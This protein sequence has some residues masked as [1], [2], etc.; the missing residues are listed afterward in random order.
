MPVSLQTLHNRVRARG[1]FVRTD[2]TDW[3]HEDLLEHFH[4]I[5][6]HGETLYVQKEPRDSAQGAR[7]RTARRMRAV[8]AQNDVTGHVLQFDEALDCA[9]LGSI[10]T[11]QGTFSHDPTAEHARVLCMHFSAFRTIEAGVWGDV[12]D[13][14]LLGG[15]E[16]L[17][18]DATRL[19]RTLQDEFVVLDNALGNLTV[20][21]TVVLDYDLVQQLDL[22]LPRDGLPASEAWYHAIA[23]H[24][25]LKRNF[26]KFD[27]GFLSHIT[28]LANLWFDHDDPDVRAFVGDA[29]ERYEELVQRFV[30][31]VPLLD[32]SVANIMHRRV[33]NRWKCLYGPERQ[34]HGAVDWAR[35]LF[36]VYANPD[37][38]D[39]TVVSSESEA[40]EETEDFDDAQEPDGDLL[41]EVEQE[42]PA[43]EPHNSG[44]EEGADQSQADE[45][46]QSQADEEDQSL[47]DEEDQW[48]ADEEDQWQ[49][50]TARWQAETARWQAET[51]QLRKQNTRLHKRLH[52]LQERPTPVETTGMHVTVQKIHWKD[53]G[54][55]TKKDFRKDVLYRAEDQAL[56]Q[57]VGMVEGTHRWYRTDVRTTQQSTTVFKRLMTEHE[58]HHLGIR[59][60]V[61]GKRA[62]HR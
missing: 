28:T 24:S 10:N 7:N 34:R 51:A 12:R 38:I 37:T 39:L 43:R 25:V 54:D 20:P 31:K 42:Q 17:D 40:E 30:R 61:L 46:D 26:H 57:Y 13:G 48:Q 58:A 22:F 27:M 49:A 14:V 8:M 45:E 55:K 29:P 18:R 52:E 33:T 11:S 15:I 3:T 59:C 19:R 2:A 32:D 47:A 35:K 16:A 41:Y 5:E 4:D 50:E 60:R 62:R 23:K 36:R 9:I 53:M 44:Q 21:S 1:Y 56:Y 6:D